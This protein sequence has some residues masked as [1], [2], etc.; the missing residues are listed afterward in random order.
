MGQGS[1]PTGSSRCLGTAEIR[2]E[3]HHS[4][5][6]GQ[7]LGQGGDQE[8]SWKRPTWK[9]AS[10]LAGR[11]SNGTRSGVGT[12]GST[13]SG[14]PEEPQGTLSRFGADLETSLRHICPDPDK[15]SA[16]G[17]AAGTMLSPFPAQQI[18]RDE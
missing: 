10:S 8:Q 12:S 17:V 18:R 4:L 2:T 11:A 3:C 15:A 9:P 16:V 13:S 14:N 1:R 7:G 6:R 5:G